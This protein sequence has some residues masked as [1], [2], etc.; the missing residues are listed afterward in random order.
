MSVTLTLNANAAE[1]IGG[2]IAAIADLLKM[3]VPPSYHVSR[4]PSPVHLPQN[5]SELFK[6]GPTCK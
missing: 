6:T 2:V 1:N 3:A 4:T 5:A